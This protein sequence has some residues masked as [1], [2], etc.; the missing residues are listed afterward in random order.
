MIEAL[1]LVSLA[2]P[3]RLRWTT[4]S[5]ALTAN[6]SPP[7]RPPSPLLRH[8]CQVSDAYK[9]LGIPPPSL[10]GVD[11]DID[12]APPAAAEETGA[13][14]SEEEEA[15]SAADGGSPTSASGDA[16]AA[17]AEGA[18]GED[19]AVVRRRNPGREAR[20]KNRSRR[21]GAKWGEE[22]MTAFN[23][24]MNSVGLRDFRMLVGSQCVAHQRFESKCHEDLNPSPTPTP[25]PAT[26][27]NEPH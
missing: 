4:S 9:L 25:I 21:G 26:P 12:G 15:S 3:H 22:E 23:A 17:A 11:D 19:A 13:A 18:E 1:A 14:P 8:R 10:P 24:A 6:H 2:R 20:P 7:G 27:L 5:R 16:A